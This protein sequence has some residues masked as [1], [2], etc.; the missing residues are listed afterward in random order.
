MLLT[1]ASFTTFPLLTEAQ[2]S[3]FDTNIV[4]PQRQPYPFKWVIESLTFTRLPSQHDRKPVDLILGSFLLHRPAYSNCT[5]GERS[6][7]R[8]SS[9]TC[10]SKE[11]GTS[12]PCSLTRQTPGPIWS[13]CNGKITDY[14]NPNPPNETRWLRWRVAGLDETPTPATRTEPEKPFSTISFELVNGK[15]YVAGSFSAMRNMLI[16]S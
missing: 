3:V 16:M 15:T 6:T 2:E 7:N 13:A 8:H 1:L 12:I 11:V 5:L 9:L 4:A 10:L 14:R